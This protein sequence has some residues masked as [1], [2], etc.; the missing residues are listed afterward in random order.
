MS[1]SST[2]HGMAEMAQAT[3]SSMCHKS[4]SMSEDC[5]DVRATPEPLQ[6]LSF[7]SAKLL[8]ALE[9]TEFSVGA[10]LAPTALQQLSVLEDDPRHGLERYTLFSSFLL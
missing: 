10:Q 3:D 4:G 7:E 5:C 2:A 9:A 6:A 8:V 1:D